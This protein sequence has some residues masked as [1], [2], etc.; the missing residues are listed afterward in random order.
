MSGEVVQVGELVQGI[1]P[2]DK[3]WTSTYYRDVRA[4]C[5]QEYVVVP[6]HTV[7]PIPCNVSMEAAACLGVAALT[8]CMTLWKWFEVPLPSTYAVTSRQEGSSQDW[9]LI[10]GGSS[11]TGQFA[12]QLAILSGLKVMTVTS[13]QTAELS[14]GLGA[15]YVVIRDGKTAERIVQEIRSV[16]ADRITKVIDLVGAQTAAI[17]LEAVSSSLPVE[18]AP[19]AMMSPEK[20]V[21]VGVK[22]HTVEMKKFVLDPSSREYAWELNRLLSE[23]KL[24]FPALNLLDGGFE[25]IIRGLDILKKGNM[26]GK[27]LVVQL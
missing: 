7:L 10:W 22:I 16:A 17:A 26:D 14:R 4:G 21:P 8:A 24:Q 27:K 5:F 6:S 15:H 23:E 20:R 9:I 1:S 2:G 25:D 3:V 18:F 11:V 19:L 12:T 13:Q